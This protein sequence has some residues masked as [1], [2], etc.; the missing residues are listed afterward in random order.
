MTD[1]IK[2]VVLLC[3]CGCASVSSSSVFALCCGQVSRDD[4]EAVAKTT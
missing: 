2:Y 4:P 3:L 1:V